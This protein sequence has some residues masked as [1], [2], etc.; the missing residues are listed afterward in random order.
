MSNV[1]NKQHD[2]ECITGLYYFAL[3]TFGE[4]CPGCC[5]PLLCCLACNILATRNSNLG[6]PCTCEIAKNKISVSF[7]A[8][9]TFD[10]EE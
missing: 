7:D 1:Q 2:F 8:P 4:I 10:G 6:M 5:L 3:P 9:P